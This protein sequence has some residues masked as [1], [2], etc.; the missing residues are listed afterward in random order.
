MPMCRGWRR[1]WEKREQRTGRTGRIRGPGTL[2]PAHA[3]RPAGPRG[4]GNARRKTPNR[5]WLGVCIWWCSSL[6]EEA[7]LSQG[8][9]HRRRSSTLIVHPRGNATPPRICSLP[10]A[11]HYQW[12]DPGPGNR[13]G[14][15]SRHEWAE[16]GVAMAHV[17]RHMAGRQKF[18]FIVKM[19]Y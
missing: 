17:S 13:T 1:F 14:V 12:F 11:T 6:Q 19:L 15:P 8:R 10:Q 16:T 3:K 2:T 7:F 9:C 18:R 5:E 4:V